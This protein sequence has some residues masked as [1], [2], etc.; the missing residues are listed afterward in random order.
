MCQIIFIGLFVAGLALSCSIAMI[1][2]R[3]R[4]KLFPDNGIV[5][6]TAIQERLEKKSR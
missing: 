3:N 6:N 1:R 4:H 5:W 2:E